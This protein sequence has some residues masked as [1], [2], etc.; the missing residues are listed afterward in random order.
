MFMLDGL[1]ERERELIT[2]NNV[3]VAITGFRCA[4]YLVW[5]TA[6]ITHLTEGVTHGLNFKTDRWSSHRAYELCRAK[7]ET[8][9]AQ[10]VCKQSSRGLA[11]NI[12]LMQL[13]SG[14]LPELLNSLPTILCS[15]RYSPQTGMCEVQ[16]YVYETQ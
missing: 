8:F 13:F 11:H 10:V 15:L 9:A 1:Q 7:S 12:T 14:L 2:R 3:H 4:I 5:R 6:H 16:L